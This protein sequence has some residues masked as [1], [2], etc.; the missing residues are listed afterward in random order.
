[1][2][3]RSRF[4]ELF[5]GF[6]FAFCLTGVEG[7]KMEGASVGAVDGTKS[8]CSRRGSGKRPSMSPF[9]L[10]LPLP[11]LHNP[12]ANPCFCRHEDRCTSSFFDANR[13]KVTEAAWERIR[14]AGIKRVVGRLW[15]CQRIGGGGEDS[16]G[17][18]RILTTG[19]EGRGR[20]SLL[21]FRINSKQERI[22]CQCV[23][24]DACRLE[25]PAFWGRRWREFE[26]GG[27]GCYVEVWRVVLITG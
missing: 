26:H 25:P 14:L 4:C 21:P 15:R 1:M 23:S 8:Q 12:G 6:C 5:H 22:T 20:R 24:R 9:E 10:E 27:I 16:S 3:S 18:E 2:P 13:G 7:V 19:I 17:R 11:V